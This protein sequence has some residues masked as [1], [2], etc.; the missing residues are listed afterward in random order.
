MPRYGR[1][2]CDAAR[3]VE[4]DAEGHRR[5]V[6]ESGAVDAIRVGAV[7]RLEIVDH[8]GDEADVV[9]VSDAGRAAPRAVIPKPWIREESRGQCRTQRSAVG[10]NYD[11]AL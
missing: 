9:H 8:R 3:E 2:R 5:A 1:D 4:P 11:E 6:G 7:V 10:E